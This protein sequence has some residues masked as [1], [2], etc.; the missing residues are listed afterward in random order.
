MALYYLGIGMKTYILKQH[1]NFAFT[2][3]WNT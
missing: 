3:S 1:H 2:K